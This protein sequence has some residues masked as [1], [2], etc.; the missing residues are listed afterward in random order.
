MSGF[1]LSY[2]KIWH[3]PIFE[4]NAQRVG[5][6]TWMLHKAA[7]KETRFR[8]GSRL[9]TLKRGQLCVSQRQVCEETGMP[10]R[11]L[12]T[13][14]GELE[15]TQAITQDT[16]QGRTVI[17]ICNYDEYQEGKKAADTATDTQPTQRRHTKEQGNNINNSS[18]NEE[19]ASA[20]VLVPSLKTTMWQ[21][22]RSYLSQHGIKN[23]GSLIGRWIKL[24]NGSVVSVLSAIEAAQTAETGD[25]VPYIEQVLKGRDGHA[26]PDIDALLRDPE[27]VTK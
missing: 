23:P 20:P 8:I 19:G 15:S 21:V 18:S 4:G 11:Q 17:T 26:Q 24:A 16:T 13:F 1:V 9:V 2:R 3:H 10:H 25:P 27:Q 14:L 22:G 7:W 5:V 12:R 6:W